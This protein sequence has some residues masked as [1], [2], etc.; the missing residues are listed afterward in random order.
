MNVDV[1]FL[2]SEITE[3]E[4][5]AEKVCIVLDIFRASSTITTALNNGCI[6]I[7]PVAEIAT[8]RTEKAQDGSILLAGERQSIKIEGFDFGNSPLEFTAKQVQGRKLVM[9]TSNGT[10]AILSCATAYRVLIGAFINAMS[11]IEHACSL[12]RDITIVC[13]G[14]GGEF[15]IED[16]LCAGYMVKLLN[17]LT[18]CS[19]SDRAYAAMLMY[20]GAA[21]ELKAHA[22]RSTNGARLYDIGLSADVEYCLNLNKLDTVC[23][24]QPS[25]EIIYKLDIIK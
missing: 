12:Q 5:L 1:K 18:D 22:G 17:E 10:K 24:Y 23:V 3:N 19:L 25:T 21:N 14:T 8:A 15:S 6:A 4:S 11:T 2:P 7:K 13:A 16:S 20:A 9:N